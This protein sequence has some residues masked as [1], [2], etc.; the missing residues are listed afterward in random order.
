MVESA[1]AALTVGLAA[2]YPLG[3]A[4]DLDARRFGLRDPAI[5][6]LGIV[7]PAAGFVVA[8][9]YLSARDTLPRADGEPDTDEAQPVPESGPGRGS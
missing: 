6:G 2:Q 3:F 7:V 5:Y 1:F 4:V 8:L 9:Y